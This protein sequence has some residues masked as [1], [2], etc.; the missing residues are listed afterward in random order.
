MRTSFNK[1]KSP[2]TGLF[3]LVKNSISQSGFS[4]CVLFLS[5]KTG[6]SC[7]DKG[8]PKLQLFEPDLHTSVKYF[9]DTMDVMK[10]PVE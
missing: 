6:S 7:T 9:L 5:L 8:N 4:Y 3:C 2:L 10:Q 1:Y